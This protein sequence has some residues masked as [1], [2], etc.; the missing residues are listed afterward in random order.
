MAGFRKQRTDSA[1]ARALV[2]P[3]MVR[4]AL[5][6]ENNFSANGRAKTELWLVVLPADGGKPDAHDQQRVTAYVPN[7]LRVVL[8]YAGSNHG[9]HDQLPAE[10]DVPVRIDP[11]SGRIVEV[12]V[13]RAATELF[14]YR[15][16]AVKEWKE[17]EAPLSDVRAAA[18]LPG[19]AVRA[20][21]G[22]LGTW[23]GALSSLRDDRSGAAPTGSFS[24]EEIEQ[25]RRSANMLQYHLARKPKEA[26]KVRASA[27]E[28]GPMMVA[29]VRGGS[30]SVAD[31][32]TWLQ[33]QATSGA[34]SAEEAEEW[35]RS[36]LSPPGK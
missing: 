22:L 2:V 5:G 29:N 3:Y 23:R 20:A 27:L 28:A 17:T 24:A 7:W 19:E 12:A 9:P 15:D 11:A 6:N 25:T 14:P 30:M 4:N 33:F 34:I 35:R 31:F 32:E 36:A 13:D 8:Y 16:V 18:A 1:A 26:A 21:K 10:I